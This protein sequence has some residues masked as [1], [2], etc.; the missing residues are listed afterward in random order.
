MLMIK[1]ISFLGG[2]SVGSSGA[3]FF[4]D[5]G[6]VGSKSSVTNAELNIRSVDSV[7]GEQQ[8]VRKSSFSNSS[9]N[10]SGTSKVSFDAKYK[11]NNASNDDTSVDKDFVSGTTWVFDN[12]LSESGVI[13][14]LENDSSE[15]EGNNNS[16]PKG[17]KEKNPRR[18]RVTNEE[19]DDLGDF[20]DGFDRETATMKSTGNVEISGSGSDNAPVVGHEFASSHENRYN[21]PREGSMVLL[22]CGSIVSSLNSVCND[23]IVCNL[24]D[25][26]TNAVSEEQ[27]EVGPLGAAKDSV[28]EFDDRR[29]SDELRAEAGGTVPGPILNSLNNKMVTSLR[30]NEALERLIG[31]GLYKSETSSPTVSAMLS[32]SQSGISQMKGAEDDEEDLDIF[33]DGFEEET[34]DMN[35]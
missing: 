18:R 14:A 9:R 11:E 31:S 34:A 5:A 1:L 10:K 22:D 7:S 32:N 24:L 2:S 19:D 21:L 17:E 13:S 16:K 3:S 8:L 15:D 28:F 6:S 4:R 20:L 29:K 27:I 33:L 30:G 23:D 25:G 35:F 12:S 26:N